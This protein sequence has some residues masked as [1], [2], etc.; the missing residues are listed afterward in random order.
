MLGRLEGEVA[1]STG[2]FLES[3]L[4]TPAPIVDLLS[5]VYAGVL[6]GLSAGIDIFSHCS[7]SWRA[8]LAAELEKLRRDDGG[9]AKA[10]EGQKSSTYYTFLV[11]LC[12]QMI[13]KPIA[14][15]QAMAAFLL[16]Q[17][18][19]D[20]GFVEIQPM[21]RSGTN[22]TA[23]AIAALKMLDNLP[24]DVAEDAQGFLANMQTDEGGLRANT[25]IPIADLLST[26]T[27][28][29]TL[30]DL[31]GT[32]L[33]DFPAAGKYAANL[34]QEEGGFRGAAWDTGTDVEYTFYGLGTLALAAGTPC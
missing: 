20:G 31:Q 3:R 2:R 7:D 33:V 32:Q 8:G 21:Q 13:D 24:P 1:A 11:L 4:A 27:G 28:L 29:L 6:L 26:F 25:R 18:R 10:A 12:H 34:Q 15:P 23:A 5:L 17:R 16:S 22:P 30:Q 14:A 9:Y 19:A